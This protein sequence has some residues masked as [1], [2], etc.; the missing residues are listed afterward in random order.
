MVVVRPPSIQ[1][2]PASRRGQFL[3]GRGGAIHS[4]ATCKAFAESL[5]QEFDNFHIW[6]LA[7]SLYIYQD[8]NNIIMD[9]CGM[10]CPNLIWKL[11]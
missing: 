2:L 3:E 6:K 11:L 7:T 10:H 9:R 5:Q 4:E 8:V 1:A